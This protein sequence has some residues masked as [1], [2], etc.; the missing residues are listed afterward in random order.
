MGADSERVFPGD[1]LSKRER[2]LRTLRHQCVDRA[3][4]HEQLSYNGAVIGRVLGRSVDGFHYTPADVGAAIR[5][6]LDSCFPI[7]DLKGTATE[8][9]PDGFVVRH[10]NWTTW[11]VSRPFAD[12]EGAARWLQRKLR[13]MER[14]GFNDHTAVQVERPDTRAAEGRFRAAEVREEHRRRMESMQALVGET[15]IIDFSFTGF[16]DLF[17]AMGLEI[18]SFFCAA[19]PGLLEEYLETSLQ[20]E[21]ARVHAVADPSLSPVILIPEDFATKQGPI[22]SPAFLRRFYYPYVDRLATAWH[23]HGYTVLYHSDGNYRE[24]IPD[25]MDCGVDGFYC[26]E[27]ACGMRIVDLKLRWPS[28]VWAGGVDGVALMERGTPAEVYREVRRQIV[29]SGALETGGMLVCTSSEI[30]PTIS[31]DNFLAMVKAVGETTNAAFRP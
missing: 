1:R 5:Q 15:V 16:C 29:E 2:V 6:T 12:E 8:R 17:D 4:I 23:E 26:L 14:S 11:R 20:N 18:F 3:A 22:F 28:M 25:L 27:P 13:L 7:F 21:I 31:A 30:N 24:A 19:H 10:E 9:L